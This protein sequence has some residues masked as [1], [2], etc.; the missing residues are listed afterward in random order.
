[1]SDFS[2]GV[3]PEIHLNYSRLSDHFVQ[4]D[5]SDERSGGFDSYGLSFYERLLSRLKQRYGDSVRVVAAPPP[6]NEAALQRLARNPHTDRKS[7]RLNSS[8]RCISY[9][10]FCLQKKKQRTYATLAARNY[11]TT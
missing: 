1:M 2:A 6:T 4:L 10:V 7:T 11:S 5:V 8:H 3:P 9:A